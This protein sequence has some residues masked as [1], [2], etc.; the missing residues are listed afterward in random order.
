[1]RTILPRISRRGVRSLLG[2]AGVRHRDLAQGQAAV[3]GGHLAMG[4]DLEAPGIEPAGQVVEQM[5][6]LEHAA[7]QGD[8]TDSGLPAR[9]LGGVLQDDR[10]PAVEARGDGTVSFTA[11]N[12]LNDG[13]D[14]R[15][16]R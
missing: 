4:E 16:D 6:V 3:V 5:L 7:A 11:A 13:A 15:S 1:M 10:Q 2:Q 12:V 14:Q 8:A 9:R